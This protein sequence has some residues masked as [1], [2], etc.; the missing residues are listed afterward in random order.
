MGG[1]VW[2][3]GLVLYPTFSDPLRPLGPLGCAF[4]PHQ[5]EKVDRFVTKNWSALVLSC[6][7]EPPGLAVL[8]ITLPP[9]LSLLHFL[10]GEN[11]RTE[12]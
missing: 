8:R 6:L 4:S 12:R 11:G 10:N 3:G 1:K 2:G 7:G 9:A 5:R